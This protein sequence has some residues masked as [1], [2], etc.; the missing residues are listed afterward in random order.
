MLLMST[1]FPEVTILVVTY[2]RPRE[3]RRTIDALCNHIKYPGPLRWHIADDH[4]PGTYIPD[5]V[6]QYQRSDIHLNHSITDRKGWGANVN[7][8][9]ASIQSDCIFLNEDDYIAIRDIDLTRGVALLEACKELGAIRYDGLE[10]H[11]LNL[12]LRE[13]KSERVDRLD[14]LI[15]D[16]DS[17]HLNVYSHR[18]HLKHRR[19]HDQLGKYVEGQSLGATEEEF[20]HRV[21]DHAGPPEI[22]ILPSGI[23]RAFAHIGKSRQG[24][25]HD[26]P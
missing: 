25:E 19:L 23:P 4:S 6:E 2:D 5:L 10:G 7:K 12:Q 3:I 14:Y 26:I 1:E 8:A 16:K 21:K 13:V 18:P 15:I 17:P 11:E 20:A 22:A 9:L 24:S